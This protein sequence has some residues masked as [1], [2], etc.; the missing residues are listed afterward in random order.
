MA[1]GTLKFKK[2]HP[3]AV[4]PTKALDGD[5]GWDLY[6]AEDVIVPPTLTATH[7]FGFVDLHC[8][9]ATKIHTGIACEFPTWT[10]GWDDQFRKVRRWGGSIRDRS[11][12]ATK[13]GLFVVAGVVDHAYRGEIIVAVHNLG[14]EHHIKA[15]ERIAQMLL[16][17]VYDI[18]VEEVTE[19]TSESDR[20]ERGFGSSGK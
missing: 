3:T 17:E 4:I 10:D 8:E 13:T 15:G 14:P 1:L 6:A 9:F 11:G 7:A 16:T 20:G 2:L 19:F 18:S 5:L 12:M